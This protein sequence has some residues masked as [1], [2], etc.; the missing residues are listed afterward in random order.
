MVCLVAEGDRWNSRNPRIRLAA[1]VD[2]IRSFPEPVLISREVG[3][4][5]NG[6]DQGL[7]DVCGRI[8]TFLI[9]F[10]S[11]IYVWEGEPRELDIDRDTDPVLLAFWRKLGIWKEPLD[12]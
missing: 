2:E 11:V 6:A 5:I 3:G 12:Q 1:K 4:L 9:G 8:G 7:E 10:E